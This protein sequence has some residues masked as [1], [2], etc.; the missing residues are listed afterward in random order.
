MTTLTS[1]NKKRMATRTGR[2]Y[3][4]VWV[5]NGQAAKVGPTPN[6]INAMADAYAKLN[7]NAGLKDRV[8]NGRIEH[9]EHGFPKKIVTKAGSETS[10]AKPKGKKGF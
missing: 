3:P 10:L 7:A 9:D 1:W 5:K 2:A 8:G 4:P 6:P